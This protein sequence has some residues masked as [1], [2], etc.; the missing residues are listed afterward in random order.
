M[1]AA[2]LKQLNNH[3]KHSHPAIKNDSVNVCPMPGVFTANESSILIYLSDNLDSS[4][5]FWFILSYILGVP[6]IGLKINQMRIATFTFFLMGR[7]YAYLASSTEHHEVVF[8]G[9]TNVLHWN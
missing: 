8:L 7:T 4:T 2:C 3:K 5:F 1:R 9:H 6:G